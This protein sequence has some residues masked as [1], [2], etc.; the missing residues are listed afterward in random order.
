VP[1]RPLIA[2]GLRDMLLAT[3]LFAVMA[4]LVKLSTREL[5][6][7]HAI[8]ARSAVGLFISLAML[9]A[10]RL[11]WRGTRPRLLFLRGV[12]GTVALFCNFHALTLMPLGDATV[13]FQTHP[14]F[15]T[16]LAGLVLREPVRMRVLAGCVV[17]L[18]GVAAVA[19]GGESDP[20]T[21]TSLLGVGLA[22]L[23]SMLS[24]GAYVSV[25]ALGASHAPLVIVFWFALV[26][27]P[28]SV[29]AVV[30]DPVVPDA[31]GWLL[32]LGI[33]ASVQAAQMLM[34]RAYRRETAARVAA[35]GYAQVVWGFA[36]GA[37]FLG[38]SVAPISAIGAAL[39]VIGALI[40]TWRTN[41]RTRTL[42][43]TTQR[44]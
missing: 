8:L 39:V 25:R 6:A 14:I 26:A 44:H 30:A 34:T 21:P 33:G 28:V 27:T 22:L 16:L 2:P 32:L 11:D 17:A 31:T 10:A 12:L 23:A 40:A 15:T 20:A 18:G 3:L 38:E 42:D 13:I 7:A 37:L 24:A 36:L 1:T 41:G 19:A 29:P 43:I 4:V 5:P 9:R 35:V